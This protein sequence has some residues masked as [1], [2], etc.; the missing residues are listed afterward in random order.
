MKLKQVI[1]GLEEK[2]E[3]TND[4]HATEGCYDHTKDGIR[5]YEIPEN[6]GYNQLL[7]REVEIEEEVLAEEAYEGGREEGDE[8]DIVKH[9]PYI[10]EY[11]INIAKALFKA[12]SEGEV[13]KLGGKNV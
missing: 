5:Y 2:E 4:P 11:W 7:N 10:Y 12:L 3:Y 8:W 6:I 13:I 9:N 1:G